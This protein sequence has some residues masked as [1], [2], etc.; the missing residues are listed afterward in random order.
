MDAPKRRIESLDILRGAA[1]VGVITVHIVFGAGRSPDGMSDGISIAE[2]L[3]AALAMFMVISGY[4]Y[5][6]GKDFRT[7]LMTRI[8]PILIV[9]AFSTI[10]FTTLMYGYLYMIGYDLGGYNLLEEIGEI[11]IGKCVFQNVHDVGYNA[12]AVLSP[13]DISAGFYYLQILA[14]GY[15]IFFAVAD[16]VLGDWRKCLAVIVSLFAISGLYVE[17]I[18]IQL[19]F[20]A[21]IGPVVA[22][23]LLIGALLKE[24]NFAEFM[25]RGFHTRKYWFM[26]VS[27]AIIGLICIK[28]FPTGMTLCNSTFGSN[29]LLSVVT[30]P[31]HAMSCGIVLW[32]IAVMLIR[33]PVVSDIFRIAGIASIVLYSMHMFIAKFISAPFYTIGTEYWITIDSMT[34]RLVLLIITLS[35]LYLITFWLYG[36]KRTLGQEVDTDY[37]ASAT[38]KL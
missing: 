31:I 9:L 36:L 23:F 22:A 4:L 33:V 34:D 6:K 1:I 28:Y 32:F 27:M 19:P 11:L 37:P 5:K 20:T 29:G 10:L 35:I 26:I 15:L 21:Q 25:E 17:F 7:N 16:R 8:L 14:V 24:Y 2:F 38:S 18:G 30:F 13:F 3:Y 12:G